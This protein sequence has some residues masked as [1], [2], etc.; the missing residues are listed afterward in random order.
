MEL[1]TFDDL[2]AAAH[3]QPQPQCLLLV[4]A[5]A[6]LPHD[7]A[8][9]HRARYERGEGGTLVPVVCVDKRPEQVASFAALCAEAEATGKAWE[10]LF[11]AALAGRNGEAPNAQQAEHGLNTVIERIKSGRISDLLTVNRHGELVQ[12][13]AG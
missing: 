4:F 3:A 11:V 8:P 13:R 5:A 1:H 9:A 7:A 6:E 10:I 12:L 2:L